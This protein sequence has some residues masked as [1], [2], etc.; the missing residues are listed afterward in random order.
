MSNWLHI[1]RTTNPSRKLWSN[2]I[3]ESSIVDKISTT[4]NRILKIKKCIYTLESNSDTKSDI[5]EASWVRNDLI[6]N[7]GI[8]TYNGEKN[9][10]KQI[11]DDLVLQVWIDIN[12]IINRNLSSKEIRALNKSLATWIDYTEMKLS[13]ESKDII[14][15]AFWSKIGN[16][17]DFVG[18]IQIN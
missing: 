18:P 13:L 8:A 14:Q 4:I 12:T 17:F 1:R 3:G 5:R 10:I 15:Q 6:Y 9:Y 7:Q 16:R 2:I 11:H